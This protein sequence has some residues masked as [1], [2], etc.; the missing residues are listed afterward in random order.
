LVL[1][2]LPEQEAQCRIAAERYWDEVSSAALALGGILCPAK[3]KGGH[4]RF[5]FR[6]GGSLGWMKRNK[7]EK[8]HGC[9]AHVLLYRRIWQIFGSDSIACCGVLLE[10]QAL[11]ILPASSQISEKISPFEDQRIQRG[12]GEGK[13]AITDLINRSRED[14]ENYQ[15]T[16]LS[17]LV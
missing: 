1:S 11:H 10:Q 5:E 17:F 6:T 12:E 14:F 7:R 8:W 13:A 9:K 4:D 2:A 16:A 15:Q 3:V